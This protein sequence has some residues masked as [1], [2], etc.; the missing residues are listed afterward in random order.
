MSTDRKRT[1]L[2]VLQRKLDKGETDVKRFVDSAASPT[3]LRMPE[4]YQFDPDW[5]RTK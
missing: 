4:L 3:N 1:R 2:E 5:S